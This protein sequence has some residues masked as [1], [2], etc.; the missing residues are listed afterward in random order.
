M[1]DFNSQIG[2]RTD[3]LI[4]VQRALEMAGVEFVTAGDH[5]VRMKEIY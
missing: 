1:E 4:R 2:A 5:G 3:S